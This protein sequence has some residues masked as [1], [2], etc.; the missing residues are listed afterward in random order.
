MC[1][2]A[3]MECVTWLIHI[4]AKLNTLNDEIAWK[5]RICTVSI[6]SVYW[7]IRGNQIFEDQLSVEPPYHSPL[8]DRLPVVLLLQMTPWVKFFW[9]LFYLSKRQFSFF[10]EGKS[11]KKNSLGSLSATMELQG[12]LHNSQTKPYKGSWKSRHSSNIFR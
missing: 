6:C 2:W 10:S 9:V 12:S 5:N 4:F 7:Q 8:S 3:K 11:S 1:S